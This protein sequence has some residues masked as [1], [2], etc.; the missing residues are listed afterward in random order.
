[1]TMKSI[2]LQQL[3]TGLFY[4]LTS[5]IIV[6]L[7]KIVLTTYK[8]PSFKVLGLGQIT[9]SI[10]VLAIARASGVVNF[11]KLGWDTFWSVWPL[12]LTYICDMLFG[13]GGTQHLS[14]PMLTVLR[15]GS[16]LFTM[17]A[18]YVVLG[19]RANLQVQLSVYLMILGGAIAASN[20][21]SFHLV[22]YIY[23]MVNNLSTAAGGV[24]MKKRLEAK[25][26]GKIRILGVHCLYQR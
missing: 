9:S 3:M 18:E 4:S 2:L 7:N 25:D 8:F 1:M 6:I 21:L 24:Y 16:I 15:H 22:G 26:L 23:V 10:V 14:L 5:L 17:I 19:V 20:D 11:P 13:L 12:P